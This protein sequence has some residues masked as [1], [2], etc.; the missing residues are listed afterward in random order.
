LFA[1]FG[2]DPGRAIGMAGV[3][4]RGDPHRDSRVYGVWTDPA[5]R[6]QGIARLL[7]HDVIEWARAAGRPRL[8]LCVM[9]E[10]VAAIALYRSLGFEEEGCASASEVHEG[11]SELAMVLRL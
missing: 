7:M 6:G 1:A 5:A 2:L 11:A 10:S 9:E 8:S 3:M 4:L